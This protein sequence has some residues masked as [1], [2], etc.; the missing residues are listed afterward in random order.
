MSNTVNPNTVDPNTVDPN[1]VDPNS[2]P[3]SSS[4]DATATARADR[5]GHGAPGIAR[6]TGLAYLGIIATGIF[7]EFVVRGTLVVDDDP[8]ATATEIADNPGLFR[9]GIGADIAMVAFDAMV[10]FGLFRLLRHVDRKLAITA[11]VWRLLQ[12]AVIAVNLLFLVSA[13]GHARDA[14]TTDGTVLAEPAQSALD[15]IERHAVGYDIGLIAFALSCFAIARLLQVSRLTP[16]WIALGM[17]ATGAVY[18]VGSFAAVF[19][20]DLL[21]VIDPFYGIALVVE[22]GFAICLLRG[23]R[24]RTVASGRPE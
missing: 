17:Y 10:A 9:A 24:P 22:F 4:A 8:L 18:L 2:S 11:T 5:G 3:T 20:P 15:A 19:A 16:R 12:G 23:L 1:T 21:A 13:L 14:V 7:A 6:L